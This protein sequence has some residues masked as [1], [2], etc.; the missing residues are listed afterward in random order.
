MH[1]NALEAVAAGQVAF[2]ALQRR[3]CL[4]ELTGPLAEY[5][6]LAA[7]EQAGDAVLAACLLCA[8]INSTRCDCL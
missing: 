3:W 6:P 1:A 7:S 5:N 2:T 4:G 8:W